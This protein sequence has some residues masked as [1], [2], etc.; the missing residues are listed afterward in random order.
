MSVVFVDDFCISCTGFIFISN[1]LIAVS[2]DGSGAVSVPVAADAVHAAFVTCG[3]GCTP[4]VMTQ[5]I[6]CTRYA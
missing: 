1:P 3:V 2:V 4:S 6:V 5:S